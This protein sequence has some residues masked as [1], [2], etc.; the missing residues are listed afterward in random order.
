MCLVCK[1]KVCLVCFL[2]EFFS[3][4]SDEVASCLQHIF[5]L[6]FLNN[7]PRVHPKTAKEEYISQVNDHFIVK[8]NFINHVSITLIK[9]PQ[10]ISKHFINVFW[11]VKRI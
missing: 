8:A 2:T 1:E 11:H 6:L 9:A 10:Q 5:L 3:Q 7:G 4:S